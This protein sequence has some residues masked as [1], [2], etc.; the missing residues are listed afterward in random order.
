MLVLLLHWF[1]E[2]LKRAI[3]GVQSLGDRRQLGEVGRLKEK[4]GMPNKRPHSKTVIQCLQ[5][6]SD[7][8]AYDQASVFRWV[9]EIRRGNEELRNEGRP[10]ET[11]SLRNRCCYSLNSAR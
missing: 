1:E 4:V 2:G 6:T 5:D 10:G 9:N 7:R 8:D 11:L 3:D